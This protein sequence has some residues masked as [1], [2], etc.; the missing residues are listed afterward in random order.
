MST[1]LSQLLALVIVYNNY[2][3][4]LPHYFTLCFSHSIRQEELGTSLAPLTAGQVLELIPSQVQYA[5]LPKDDLHSERHPQLHFHSSFLFSLSTG[6][7]RYIPGSGPNPSATVGVA[8]PFT[9]EPL[10]RNQ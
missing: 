10:K 2:T 8:D 7:G 4:F 6:S 1:F 5:C 3:V 9:G